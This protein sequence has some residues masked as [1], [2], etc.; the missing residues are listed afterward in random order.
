V[1]GVTPAVARELRKGRARP[2]P[3]QAQRRPRLA[4]LDVVLQTPG[5]AI[6]TAT[7]VDGGPVPYRIVVG[8]ERRGGR[9]L[10]FDLGND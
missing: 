7:V 10:V 2:T 6:A 8:L 5:S 1:R 3:A 9:W 4:G